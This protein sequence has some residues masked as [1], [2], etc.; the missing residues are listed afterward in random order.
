MPGG[1]GEG[2]QH[3]EVSRAL[4]KYGRMK[5]RVSRLADLPTAVQAA[6]GEGEEVLADSL[7]RD[8]GQAPEQGCTEAQQQPQPQQQQQQQQQHD[9]QS[10]LLQQQHEGGQASG[11]LVPVNARSSDGMQSHL[12][13]AVEQGSFSAAYSAPHAAGADLFCGEPF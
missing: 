5:Q 3:R 13:P 11:A 12:H 8:V 9:F 10:L 7:N 6:E 2:E 1:G 4:P